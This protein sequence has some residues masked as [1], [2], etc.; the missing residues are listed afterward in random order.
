MWLETLAKTFI[1]LLDTIN[2]SEFKSWIKNPENRK[3]SPAVALYNA[4]QKSE[5]GKSYFIAIVKTKF[6]IDLLECFEDKEVRDWMF[7]DENYHEL[8]EYLK[9]I[10]LLNKM[11]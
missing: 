9:N 5:K 4:I 7:S 10:H 8:V 6:I 1:S 3:V 2:L 11:K